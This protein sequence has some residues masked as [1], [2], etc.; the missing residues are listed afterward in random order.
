MR[1]FC[2]FLYSFYTPCIDPDFAWFDPVIHAAVPPGVMRKVVG[3]PRLGAEAMGPVTGTARRNGKPRYRL[4]KPVILPGAQARLFFQG[5][6]CN[7][8]FDCFLFHNL[9][10][11]AFSCVHYVVI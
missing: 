4:G 10:L 7:K 8:R 9:I 2:F 5:Q 6:L 11:E 3:F 1:G